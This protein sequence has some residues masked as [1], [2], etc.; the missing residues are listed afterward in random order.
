MRLRIGDWWEQNAVHI[1]YDSNNW[2]SPLIIGAST[3]RQRLDLQIANWIINQ[4]AGTKNY[5]VISQYKLVP[6]DICHDIPR[7]PAI[8]T[9]SFLYTS[10]FQLFHCQN[11]LLLLKEKKR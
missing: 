3:Q 9:S 5:N 2:C 1:I 7:V 6:F 11:L 10:H 8:N 4:V